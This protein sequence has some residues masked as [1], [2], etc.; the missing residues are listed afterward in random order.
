MRKEISRLTK[1]EFLEWYELTKPERVARGWPEEQKAMALHLGV[2][3]RTV[4]FW[5]SEYA[6]LYQAPDVPA[7]ES[8]E[9][10]EAEEDGVHDSKAW[11]T[12]RTLEM[13][14]ALYKEAIAGNVRAIELVKKMRGEFDNPKSQG[15]DGLNADEIQRRNL[16]AGNELRKGKHRVA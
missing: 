2:S 6:R 12:K 14:R 11:W 4:G 8:E 16:V 7:E 5:V 13:D 10:A 1:A 9:E 15:E 3:Y